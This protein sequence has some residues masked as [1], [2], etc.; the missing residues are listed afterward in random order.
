MVEWSHCHGQEPEVIPLSRD[1]TTL[2]FLEKFIKPRSGWVRVC[3]QA[4]PGTPKRLKKV[5][6][7]IVPE[8][9]SES[10]HLD[11]FDDTVLLR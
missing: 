1:V 7:F 6:S 9:Q 10:I 3:F 11:C 2:E 4:R 8:L 5:H